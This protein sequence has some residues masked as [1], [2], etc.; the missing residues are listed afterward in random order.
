MRKVFHEGG[1][2]LLLE[3]DGEDEDLEEDLEDALK[4]FCRAC[5][6]CTGGG[7]RGGLA[8]L[9]HVLTTRVVV[10]ASSNSLDGGGR[11]AAQQPP[12]LLSLLLAPIHQSIRH[13]AAR[14]T[15]LET[16]L[17]RLPLLVAVVVLVL[18]L[19]Q[20]VVYVRDTRNGLGEVSSSFSPSASAEWRVTCASSSSSSSERGR[21]SS[22][23]EAVSSF[24][25]SCASGRCLG[26]AATTYLARATTATMLYIV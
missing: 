21:P 9:G 14:R 24:V 6:L 19:L 5:A 7:G 1:N 2:M 23:A 15:E 25:H 10:L 8:Q 12:S 17:R 4:P 16:R 3:E 26:M 13:R 20:H 22:S 18:V 11:Q